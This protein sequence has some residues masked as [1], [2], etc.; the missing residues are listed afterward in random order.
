MR[1]S[2][3][4]QVAQ[5]TWLRLPAFF[6]RVRLDEYIVMPNHLHAILWIIDDDG[7]CRIQGKSEVDVGTPDDWHG[8][9]AGSLGAIIQNYKSVVTRKIH[10]LSRNE[11]SDVWQRNY[12]ERVIRNGRELH[13]IRKY[14]VDNP[15]QW[16][17]DSM[18][19]P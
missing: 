14:I 9:E 8:T 15:A 1:L 17:M 13:A 11:I 6:N 4:G 2:L 18:N 7:S 3:A 10:T 12:W 5:R 16:E 19:R